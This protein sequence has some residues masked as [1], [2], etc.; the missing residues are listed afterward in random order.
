M[1]D[2][3]PAPISTVPESES[4]KERRHLS[5]KQLEALQRGREKR[6]RN[7]HPESTPPEP[8]T[9]KRTFAMDAKDFER[10]EEQAVYNT[11]SD[12]EGWETPPPPRPTTKKLSKALRK[13]LDQY[14]EEKM[15]AYRPTEDQYDE[16]PERETI[17]DRMTP[18]TASYTTSVEPSQQ[19]YR[20]M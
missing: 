19:P 1:N 3:E 17:L 12:S 20:F 15:S 8:P 14:I 18:S 11:S 10:Q 6:W 16:G 13:R 2:P 4:K 7:M 9:L 5:E